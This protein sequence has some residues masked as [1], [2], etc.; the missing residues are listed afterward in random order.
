MS[1]FICG[2]SYAREMGAEQH[3]PAYLCHLPATHTIAWYQAGML[4]HWGHSCAD[5]AEHMR[6]VATNAQ[7]V[8][9]EITEGLR[10]TGGFND[11]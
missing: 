11:H 5:H 3:D 9:M 2:Y 1:L 8:S 7:D 10:W 6:H 4:A